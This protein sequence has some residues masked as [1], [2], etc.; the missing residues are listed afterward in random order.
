MNSQS[1]AH[2]YKAG[3]IGHRMRQKLEASPDLEDLMLLRELDDE[4][5]VCGAIVGTVDEALE[6]IQKLAEANG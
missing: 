4:G 2:E 1:T 3:T 5:R 6:Y